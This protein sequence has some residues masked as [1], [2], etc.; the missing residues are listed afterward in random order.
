MLNKYRFR[1]WNNYRDEPGY[2]SDYRDGEYTEGK[3]YERVTPICD[4]PE[5]PDMPNRKP[6]ARFVDDNGLDLWEEVGY[7]DLVED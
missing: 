2:L 4:Y 5:H 6:D 1:G 7:F 3:I